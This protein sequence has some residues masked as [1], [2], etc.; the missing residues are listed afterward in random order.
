MFADAVNLSYN[1]TDD[2]KP[3][4]YREDCTLKTTPNKQSA[5]SDQ[6]DLSHTIKDI[7]ELIQS[8]EN[9]LANGALDTE[10]SQHAHN[11]DLNH[12]KGLVAY[13]QGYFDDADNWIRKAI[14][15]KPDNANYHNNLG[16]VYK[17]KGLL[18]EAEQSYRRSLEID[19]NLVDGISN[20]G[21]CFWYTLD[22]AD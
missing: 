11:P 12:L 2:W 21:T 4:A 18:A 9:A 6:Q 22:A 7:I 5:N 20:L 8:G 16:N 10:L 1:C 3:A 14:F 17:A 19:P 13:Q 15:I